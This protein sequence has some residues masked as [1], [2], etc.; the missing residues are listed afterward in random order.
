MKKLIL[1]STVALLWSTYAI[2]M[3]ITGEGYG[4]TKKEAKKESLADLSQRIQVEIKSEFSTTESFNAKGYDKQVVRIINL[5]SDLPLIGIDF[6]VIKAKNQYYSIATLDYKTTSLYKAE[7]KHIKSKV[8]KNLKQISNI[9][10]N[11]EKSGL[12]K[13]ILTKLDQYNKYRIVAQFLGCSNIPEINTSKAEIRDQLAG[14]EKKADTIDFGIKKIAKSIQMK[15]IYIYPAT[16]RHSSEI[17][18]FASA[19]KDRLAIYLD[20][21]NSPQKAGYY[22]TGEYHIL[23]KSIDLTL[24]LLDMDQNT[25]N[26]VVTSF[27]PAA[28]KNY[29][30]EP[31][32]VDFDKL[33]KYGV[34][35][36]GDFRAS[37]TTSFGRKDLIFKNKDSF[38]LLAKMN[39]PGYFYFVVHNHKGKNKYSYLLDFYT[40]EGNRKF[41]YHINADDLNKWIELGEFEVIPPFGIESIQMIASTEDLVDKVPPNYY[42]SKTNLY[43]IGNDPFKILKNT[44]GFIRKDRIN[45]N[46]ESQ[47]AITEAVL[48]LTTMQ[49]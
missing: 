1:I 10:S 23:K 5:K 37:V 33:L 15:N 12:L 6:N 8:D 7:L 19:V 26:T 4:K 35:V 3:Q 11:E 24:H 17:T 46:N 48:T 38:K 14:L 40:G 39:K 41:I 32:T 43:T 42:D 28:Y 47:P 34:V 20:T 22:L 13:E 49:D 36:S 21:V 27:L 44:R 9:Q 30:I 25:I 2:A 31:K 18:E 29:Q 16:T 45:K